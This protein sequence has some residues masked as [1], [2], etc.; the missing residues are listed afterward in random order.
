M[1]RLTAKMVFSGLVT[2]WRLAG[3]PTS[4]SPSSVNAT[5]EGVVRMPSAFS[6][7][8]GVL[9]S[10]TATHELVVPRSMPM[11]LPMCGPLNCGRPAGPCSA[12]TGISAAH[13]PTPQSSPL[14]SLSAAGMRLNRSYRRGVMA[15]KMGQ[16]Q[17]FAAHYASELDRAADAQ[18][19]GVAKPLG[20]H[21]RVLPAVR[22]Y[23]EL[24]IGLDCP[25][26]RKLGHVAR[27]E[28]Q[29]VISRDVPGGAVGRR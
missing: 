11:T 4:R 13:P 10:M 3:C 15:R 17:G 26:G 25:P 16:S 1:R 2:A 6:M 9:P 23:D 12:R 7:T 22:V 14:D 28:H 8:F 20:R 18:D 29:L 27:L 5:M 21:L 24:Q 19:E